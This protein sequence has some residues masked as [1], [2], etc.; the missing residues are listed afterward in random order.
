M[1]GV[2]SIKTFL[3][4]Q[5]SAWRGKPFYSN[6]FVTK[7]CN[8][9]CFFCNVAGKTKDLP[10][11]EIKQ[12]IDEMADFGIKVVAVTGGEPLLRDDIFEILKHLESRKIAYSMISNGTLWSEEKAGEMR[13]RK[14]LTLSFSL[15][16]LD[17][18]KYK[19]IRGIN[20]LPL[21]K[22]TIELFK[23]KPL[24]NGFVS[25]LTTVT[26]DNVGEVFDL[27]EFDR[28]KNCKFTCAPVSLGANFSFRSNSREK[29]GLSN[30]RLVQVF[31]KLAKQC[32]TDKTIIGPSLYY[33]NIADHYRGKFKVPCD[34]GTYY[35]SVDSL[36]GVSVCQDF[37]ATGNILKDG[38]AGALQNT[39]SKKK[40]A[41][42]ANN[43]PCFYGCSTFISM[44]V[45]APFHKK[46]AFSL[47]ELRKGMV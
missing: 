30:E 9:S 7:R 3:G 28:E 11:E 23:E 24:R 2:G 12:I 6:L 15:D 33:Q 21:V 41:A 43:S 1:S 46:I 47:E 29:T 36:G 16:T 19:K 40:I 25:T 17:E 34:A 13:K 27:I 39:D 14:P 10:L 35:I 38:I 18:K 42:C 45:R 4:C 8:S 44:L 20:G 26:N 32:K 5:L 31:E 22:K 37:P